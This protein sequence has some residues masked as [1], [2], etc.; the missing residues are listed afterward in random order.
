M[1]IQYIYDCVEKDEQLNLEDYRLK[2]EAV[3]KPSLRPSNSNESLPR[4]SGGMMQ[5]PYIYYQIYQKIQLK[6]KV[7]LNIIWL[8]IQFHCEQ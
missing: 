8:Y 1:S 2:P 5:R 4:L 6:N 7:N 3:E